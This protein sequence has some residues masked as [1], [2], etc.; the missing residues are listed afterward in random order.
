NTTI[1]LNGAG[2]ASI[3]DGDINNGSTDACGIAST[4]LSEYNFDC[5]NTGTNTVYLSVTDVNGNVDSASA[6]VTVLDTISPVAKV[7]SITAYLDASGTVVVDPADV[8]NGSSDN[9]GFTLSL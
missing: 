7:Q 8:D 5:S 1:Y 4:S 2:Q 3:V 6:T 9:C